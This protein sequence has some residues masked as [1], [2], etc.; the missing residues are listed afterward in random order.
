MS[1]GKNPVDLTPLAMRV[2]QLV[3]HSMDGWM[4]PGQPLQPVA[5][6]AV[7][8]QF[9]FPVGINLRTRP[10]DQEG[11]TFQ[12]LR[13][14]ADAHDVLRT[15]IETRKDELAGLA[16]SITSKDDKVEPDARCKEVTEFLASPDKEHGWD[17]WL[18]MLLE[19]LIVLDAPTAYVH[20]TN[21]GKLYALEPIDGATIKRVLDSA[22][23]TPIAPAP[24]YQQIIKGL[25]AI[26][27]T[28]EELVYRP[29]NPRTNRIY[30]YSPV[31][32]IIMTVNIAL[33][34]QLAVLNHYTE[35]NIPAAFIGVPDTWQPAQIAQ[36]QAYW[37]SLMNGDLAQKRRAKFVP[38][39]I[40]KNIHET[41][42]PPL[43]DEY[44]EWIA[45]I[46]CFAFSISP[47][48]FIKNQN[49]ATAQTAQ[50]TAEGQGLV[51]Y[52]RWIKN[53]MDFIVQVQFG[54]TDLE[55]AWENKDDI[56]VMVQAQVDQIYINS[57]VTSPDEVR[58]RLGLAGPAP[59]PTKAEVVKDDPDAD[60]DAE[61]S[62]IVT[63]KGWR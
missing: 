11:V 42:T 10:R 52:K 63:Y 37:D 34:R 1:R 20:R 29:R 7:G 2:A 55:F 26:D 46:V 44:D 32:Q 5:Q 54:Y 22:G 61:K 3:P 24:A 9:D 62:L 45:R 18:R 53:L 41:Q 33:N 19:D 6:Q 49:R 48:P 17:E 43:K 25:P 4:G 13:S 28:T 23:R 16:W 60:P 36:F 15:V 50:E 51:P 8:R 27:Y 58:G 14:L 35:G 31:E 39:D 57:G 56:D 40:A 59:E 38:G 47:T 12:Q 30:G 21:G